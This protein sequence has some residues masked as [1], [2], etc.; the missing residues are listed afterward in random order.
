MKPGLGQIQIDPLRFRQYL[1]YLQMVNSYF[2]NLNRTALK[3]HDYGISISATDTEREDQSVHRK[4]S[5][6]SIPM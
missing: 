6:R 1:I 5:F 3:V 4:T 2:K